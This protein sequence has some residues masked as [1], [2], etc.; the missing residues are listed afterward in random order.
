MCITNSIVNLFTC[1]NTEYC[2][3]M[4]NIGNG[5]TK[6]MWMDDVK[7]NLAGKDELL[8]YFANN[9]NTK[10]IRHHPIW[11]VLHLFCPILQVLL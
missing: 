6:Q 4:T 10:F 2:L 7:F 1:N 5:V 9:G 3:Q 8:N 11:F